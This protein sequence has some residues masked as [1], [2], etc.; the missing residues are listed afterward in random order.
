MVNPEMMS[1]VCIQVSRWAEGRGALGTAMEFAQAAALVLPRDAAPALAAGALAMRWRRLA[2][3]E[4]WLRRAIGLARQGKQWEP[5]AQAYVELGA[6]YVRRG[7]PE[8]AE[9]FYLKGWRAARRFGLPAVRG[10]AQHGLLVQAM[11]AG[12]LE[13]AERYARGALKAYGRGHPRLPELRHDVAFLHVQQEHYERAITLLQRLL[14][15]RVEPVERAFTLAILA[16]AA[17]GY[18]DTLLYQQSWMD[19]W[20]IVTRHSPAMGEHG[21][22]L[23]ELARSSALAGD[24]NHVEQAVRAASEILSR[25]SDISLVASLDALAASARS[26]R[27]GLTG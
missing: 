23:L 6:L 21:R 14:P 26:G 16:R 3:A 12:D 5:Y 25:Q 24:W 7:Q 15:S 8:P 4:T 27:Q 11:E 17:A 9:R 19:A 10:A 13:E 2:R 1:L 18:G 20:V 22:A